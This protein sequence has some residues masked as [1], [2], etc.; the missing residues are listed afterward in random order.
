LSEQEKRQEK[1]RP[2]RKHFFE[3][4]G[5]LM[6]ELDYFVD[7]LHDRGPL[8]DDQRINLAY[9][10]GQIY[11]LAIALAALDNHNK[12]LDFLYSR[13]HVNEFSKLVDSVED[14]HYK[15]VR[16]EV[17]DVEEYLWTFGWLLDSFVEF[18]VRA[19]KSIKTA[20]PFD[21]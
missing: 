20:S 17:K 3:E 6:V 4:N 21:R 7:S 14:Y 16:G 10:L 1:K 15:L 12:A 19:I 11:G 8:D 9:A 13:R 2:Q 5:R 18:T